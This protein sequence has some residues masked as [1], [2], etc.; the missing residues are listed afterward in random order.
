MGHMPIS[1]RSNIHDI[2]C[3]LHLPPFELNHNVESSP[4]LVNVNVFLRGKRNLLKIWV[5]FSLFGF[6]ISYKFLHLPFVEDLA[7]ILHKVSTM[8]N[9]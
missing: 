9:L 3:E 4:E 1:V 8:R 5:L 7:M 6:K 2:T